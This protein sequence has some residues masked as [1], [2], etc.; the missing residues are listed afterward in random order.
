MY[1]NGLRFFITKSCHIKFT[2]AQFITSTKAS[3]LMESF[4]EVHCIYLLRGFQITTVHMDG[5]FKPLEAQLAAV[6]ADFNP[7][8]QN[9]HVKEIEQ[10]IQTVKERT[11][12]TYVTLP[13]DRM[14]G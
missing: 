12:G 8:L 7:V 14:P 9:K 4:I 13:F 10:M 2:T 3:S 6:H 1:V 11:R 5:Q